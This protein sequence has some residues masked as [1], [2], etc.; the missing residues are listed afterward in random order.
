MLVHILKQVVVTVAVIAVCWSYE[1][2]DDVRNLSRYGM[3]CISPQVDEKL[4]GI[5]RVAVDN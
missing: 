1:V 5:R 3:A 4:R 2:C